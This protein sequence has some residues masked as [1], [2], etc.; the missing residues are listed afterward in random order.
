M[1]WNMIPTPIG[2]VEPTRV[3]AVE[4]RCFNGKYTAGRQPSRDL[5]HDRCWIID[6]LD[7]VKHRY[8][9]EGSF[10]DTS[11]VLHSFAESLVTLLTQWGDHALV[12]FEAMIP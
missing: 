8:E 5:T 4:V 7:D 6:M 9:I 2:V 11:A 12:Q 3:D 10:R 1:A